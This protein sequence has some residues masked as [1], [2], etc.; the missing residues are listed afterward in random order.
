MTPADVIQTANDRLT[1]TVACNM[2]GM[3]VDAGVATSMK[4]YCPFGEIYHQD[5]GMSKSFRVYPETNSAW[6]FAGCGYFNP[7]R[8]VAW[9]RDLTDLQA[10]EAILIETNYVPENY[11]S[12]WEDLVQEREFVDTPSLSQALVTACHRMS[13]DWDTLQFDSFVAKRLNQCL[14]LLPKVRTAYDADLWLGASREV[15]SRALE[16]RKQARGGVLDL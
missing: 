2:I 3:D 11:E 12:K 9:D 14:G 16:G 1:I 13:P 5:G 10:A 7:V 6:C 4:L 15:M 8:L